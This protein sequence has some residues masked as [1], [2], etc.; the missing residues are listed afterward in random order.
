MNATNYNMNIYVSS[1]AWYA[2]PYRR[3]R[4]LGT[5]PPNIFLRQPEARL[6]SRRCFRVTT[7]LIA[8][9]TAMARLNHL[10]NPW[11]GCVMGNAQGDGLVGF[12][13]EAIG[14]MISDGTLDPNIFQNKVLMKE[15][16]K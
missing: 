7:E 8:N 4:F 11:F 2:L 13:V 10:K 5:I 12:A 15:W 16:P 6:R 1:K 14:Q 9:L 3:A